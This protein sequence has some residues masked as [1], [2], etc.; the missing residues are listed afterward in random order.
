MVLG[1][2]YVNEVLLWVSFYV[3]HAWIIPIT[4]KKFGGVAPHPHHGVSPL[5]H[6]WLTG[7]QRVPDKNIIIPPINV[8]K[9][10]ISTPITWRGANC[11]G[12]FHGPVHLWG[13]Y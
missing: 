3:A 11:L 8:L 5:D 6:D 7:G 13:S 12:V 9:I 10:V 1:Q 2:Y 4:C